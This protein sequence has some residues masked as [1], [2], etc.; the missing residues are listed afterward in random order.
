M[1]GETDQAIAALKGAINI[2]PN[3][4]EAYNNIG[5]LFLQKK[6]YEDAEK[7]LKT[8][9]DI[10]PYYGKAFYNL[11]RL[12]L[13]KNEEEK[14]WTYFKKATEGDL[15]VGEGFYTLG[16]MSL[17]MKK[18]EEAVKAFEQVLI[19]G[20]PNVQLINQVQFNL[21]NS[22]FM[23][24]ELDK[25]ENIYERLAQKEPLN[26]KYLYNLAETL[27]AKDK[28]SQAL[29]LFKKITTLPEPLP[30]SHLRIVACHEKLDQLDQAKFYLTDLLNANAPDQFKNIVKEELARIELKEKV[31]EGKGS[32]R[33]SELQ[34]IIKKATPEQKNS[35]AKIT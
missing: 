22:Y 33:M 28:L 25:A 17:R 6:N 11:G 30:Q 12:Y 7:M 23:L 9:I 31:T 5:T 34:N 2:F 18:Y 24:K 13:E 16:Q 3:Y 15:D 29:M 19:K 1:K 8:A 21:A 26:G 10:R 4:A 20:L 27:F 14:A 32:I 35:E